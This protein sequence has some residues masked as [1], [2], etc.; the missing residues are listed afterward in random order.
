M[1]LGWME[2]LEKWEKPRGRRRKTVCYWRKLLRE[3]GIDWTDIN[4]KTKD[5]KVWK[6]SV[7][8]RMRWLEKWEKSRG[9]L[10]EGESMERNKAGE[11]EVEFVCDVCQK[12]C[13][14][15]GGLVIHR[16]R[17]HEVSARK[18]VF[19]CE[20]CRQSFQQEANLW[21]HKKV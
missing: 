1:I 9:H 4:G 17:M 18:K 13:K 15:K 14:S 2:E 10:W 20:G 16:R 8:E 12:K 5:R 21:N 7:Q 6:A 19:E 3:A 11:K